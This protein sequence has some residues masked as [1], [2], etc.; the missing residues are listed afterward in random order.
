MWTSVL[1]DL[2]VLYGD[3]TQADR[4]A[5]DDGPLGFKDPLRVSS[6]VQ[7]RLRASMNRLKT[8]VASVEDVDEDDVDYTCALDRIRIAVFPERCDL[9][10]G[11]AY[12]DE[13]IGQGVYLSW[14]S[15]EKA[16]V[17]EESSESDPRT[18]CDE[19]NRDKL[20]TC[21]RVSADHLDLCRSFSLAL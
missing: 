8:L 19:A 13:L 16:Y 5:H 3:L 12:I 4:L 7:T 9:P 14:W 2:V 1:K 15:C 17:D 6:K 11:S 18:P 10:R 21:A 20:R